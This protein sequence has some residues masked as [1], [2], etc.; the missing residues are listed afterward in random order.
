ML[1]QEENYFFCS[2]IAIYGSLGFYKVRPSYRRSLQPSK[3]NIQHF[4][5]KF[6]N[7]VEFF[8]FLW[9][10]FALLDPDPATKIYADPCGTGS[11]T[12]SLV[13]FPPFIY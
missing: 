8:L 2:K 6:L 13:L 4:N 5:V 12:L 9:F 1:Q 7:L 10:I 11:E 3:N